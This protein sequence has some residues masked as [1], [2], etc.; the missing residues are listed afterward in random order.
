MSPSIIVTSRKKKINTIFLHKSLIDCIFSFLESLESICTL[1]PTAL[2]C[3]DSNEELR[4]TEDFIFLVILFSL[5]LAI[6]RLTDWTLKLINIEYIMEKQFTDLTNTLLKI[7]I[8]K[9][10][11]RLSGHLC[12]ITEDLS[13][14]WIVNLSIERFR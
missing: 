13:N 9:C 8:I 4:M 12:L 3:L 7:R 1:L 5:V 11:I 2:A 10:G 14:N 6:A